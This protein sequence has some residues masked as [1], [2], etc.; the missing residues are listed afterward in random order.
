MNYS[1][2]P[3]TRSEYQNLCDLHSESIS[4]FDRL[5]WHDV[6]L[7]YSGYD[8]Y[9]IKILSNEHTHYFGSVFV[10]N[11]SNIIIRA[12]F[13]GIKM[14]GPY[15]SLASQSNASISNLLVS[16]LLLFLTK[17]YKTKT[18]VFEYISLC[19][20]QPL[21]RLSL[22]SLKT[23][24]NTVLF[25]KEY[26]L[27]ITKTRRY[28]ARRARK[29]GVTVHKISDF[30]LLPTL[31]SIYT[32]SYARKR[33]YLHENLTT[34]ERIIKLDSASTYVADLNGTILGFQTF[35]IDSDKAY[36]VFAA[37]TE[38]G[39][40]LHASSLL[41]TQSLEDLFTH[42]KVT[43]VDSWGA[44]K[45]SIKF[46]KASY[47]GTPFS[48]TRCV[49]SKGPLAPLVNLALAIKTLHSEYPTSE[50]IANSALWRLFE[51]PSYI[52]T[53]I[54]ILLRIS[55]N[56]VTLISFICS[57]LGAILLSL[58]FPISASVLFLSYVFLD[59]VDGTIARFLGLQSKYGHFL[60]TI[61]GY[62]S[63]CLLFISL[64][65][66]AYLAL[67]HKYLALIC[68]LS[69]ISNILMRLV[70][71]NSLNTFGA[72]N[73][74]VTETSVPLPR[75]VDLEIGLGGMMIPILLGALYLN[76]L[77]LVICAYSLYY[78]VMSF[79]F[80][81]STI[82]SVGKKASLHSLAGSRNN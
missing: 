55:P 47:G 1:I 68:L 63:Q 35:I 8:L 43:L 57:A 64:G 39:L 65:I 16:Q 53:A 3:I 5:P 66:Y 81:V 62:F 28:E 74:T 36:Q 41:W 17:K 67:D 30:K 48:Y 44:N 7:T 15:K 19:E 31:Y 24:Y 52:V 9:F 75:K 18:I 13:S 49:Y 54:C 40:R 21:H 69:A 58:G 10:Q 51:Y 38:K 77:E 27:G 45:K 72:S 33:L 25:S 6:C 4:L 80:I 50:R 29:S 82:F 26:I 11:S 22:L 70:Y 20:F 78:I 2:Q 79:L 34:F 56:I 71:Q 46:A 60:D 32:D 76:A 42:C 73:L 61:V 12:G 37:Y 23:P 14:I 59:S